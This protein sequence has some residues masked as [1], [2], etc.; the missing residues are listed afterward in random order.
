[1]SSSFDIQFEKVQ[2]LKKNLVNLK[3]M[4][5]S[6]KKELD[7]E[8]KNLQ[9]VCSHEFIEES[10]GDY[11]KPGYYY[12]CKHCAYFTRYNPESKYLNFI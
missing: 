5:Q 6:K 4:Y 11:H 9:Q 12:T 2:E 10:D 7:F 8:I 3:M 1:M